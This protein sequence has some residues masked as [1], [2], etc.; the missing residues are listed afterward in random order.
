MKTQ[1]PHTK[2][3]ATKKYGIFNVFNII[4]KEGRLD[5]LFYNL[6]NMKEQNTFPLYAC[7][8][9]VLELDIVWI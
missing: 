3:H 1:S 7:F 2:G 4:L 9:F 8:P 6:S 5:M